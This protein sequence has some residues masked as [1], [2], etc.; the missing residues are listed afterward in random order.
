MNG[1]ASNA[2]PMPANGSRP[3]SQYAP[4]STRGPYSSSVQTANGSA[5]QRPPMTGPAHA[6]S[7]QRNNSVPPPLMGANLGL[8]V[9]PP[10]LGPSAAHGNP[11]P[12]SPAVQLILQMGAE[13]NVQAS[14]M[15]SLTGH[16]REG[17]FNTPTLAK[18]SHETEKCW[19]AAGL[20]DS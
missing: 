13:R 14:Q 9:E 17:G 7:Q 5:A 19:V 10:G 6:S 12:M 2:Q 18:L 15:L 1:R 3:P 11:S 20:L 16:G 8:A 4:A